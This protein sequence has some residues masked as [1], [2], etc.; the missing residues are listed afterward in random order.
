MEKA[1]TY[2]KRGTCTYDNVN[3]CHLLS[4]R[5]ILCKALPETWN[6]GGLGI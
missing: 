1:N 6:T 3:V 5:S 2:D 4:V